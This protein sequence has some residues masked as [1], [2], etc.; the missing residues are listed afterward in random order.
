MASQLFK[1]ILLKKLSVVWWLA[2]LILYSNNASA[3]GLGTHIYFA[4]SLLWAM[5]MLDSRLRLAIQNFPDLVMAGACLPDLAVISNTFN[6]THQWQQGLK[7]INA[8][9]YADSEEELAIAIGYMSHLYIDVIAHQ[10]FVPAHEA[11]W[12]HDSIATHIAAEWAMDA[13]LYPITP[14]SPSQLLRKNHLLLTSFVSQ[15]FNCEMA[16]ASKMLNRLSFW[17][18]LLRGFKIPQ[19]IYHLARGF[20]AQIKHHF[21]Y[22][23]ALTQHAMP[24]IKLLLEGDAPIYEAELK[25]QS[26]D[27]MRLWQ[28]NCLAHLKNLTRRPI[29]HFKH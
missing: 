10:H 3:W 2:P 6:S 18:S 23:I 22:Y 20:D 15:Y 9:K 11:L 13:Y 27:E 16:H 29:I 25:L 5:P 26:V 19:L 4:H 14:Q 21:I 24:Q 7:L 28:A 8:A 17:D 1:C 12:R